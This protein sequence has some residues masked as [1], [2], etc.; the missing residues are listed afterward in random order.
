MVV[1]YS[2]LALL[3]RDLLEEFLPYVPFIPGPY[4]SLVTSF[5]V[6]CQDLIVH[7]RPMREFYS[8]CEIACT[9]A[10]NVFGRFSKSF[11]Q[12]KVF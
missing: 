10:R 9:F 6:S 11:V 12:Q 1:L 4:C 8:D 5:V 3:S 2:L 7:A